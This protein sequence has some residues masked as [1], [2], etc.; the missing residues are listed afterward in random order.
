MR[1]RPFDPL[2]DALPRLRCAGLRQAHRHVTVVYRA[3]ET[4]CGPF[5]CTPSGQRKA[6]A[7]EADED[8]RGAPRANDG[9]RA[10]SG[11]DA[12]TVRAQAAQRRSFAVI[13]HPDAGKS[14][15]TEALALHAQVIGEAGA[16]HGKA[17]RRG[18]TA[19]GWRWSA[20]AASR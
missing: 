7:N 3:T 18:V 1:A 9:R 16:V 11:G 19:T 4:R 14:T 6:G 5:V 12:A 10:V 15:L 13:S 20:S 17:G 2:G 8:H